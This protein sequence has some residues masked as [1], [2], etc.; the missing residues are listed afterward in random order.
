VVSGITVRRGA[1]VPRAWW[2]R[3]QV[4]QCTIW[5]ERAGPEQEDGEQS[6]DLRDG[7]RDHAGANR[8]RLLGPG[9]HWRPGISAVPEQGG[10]DGADR[11]AAIASSTWRV[12]VV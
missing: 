10:R 1:S 6:P 5:P 2:R 3:R 4:N 8:G 9:R 12:I 11:Q 7:Q